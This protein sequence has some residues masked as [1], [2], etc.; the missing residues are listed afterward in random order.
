[1]DKQTQPTCHTHT[2]T[3]AFKL[4]VANPLLPLMIPFNRNVDNAVHI[5][6]RHPNL[7]P[8]PEIPPLSQ[9]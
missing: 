1:M 8:H 3:T 4:D 2:V 6:Q 5:L 7:Q 9:L